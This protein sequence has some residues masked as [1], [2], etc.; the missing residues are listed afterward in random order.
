MYVYIHINICI[1]I[2]LF[3]FLSI[4]LY[5]YLYIPEV[6]W[7]IRFERGV[8]VDLEKPRLEVGVEHHIKAKDL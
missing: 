2:Y 4:H 7:G 1:S 6:E 8:Q 5:L 3:S